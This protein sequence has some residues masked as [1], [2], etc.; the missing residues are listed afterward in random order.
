MRKVTLIIQYSK[1]YESYSSA[2]SVVWRKGISEESRVIKI[3]FYENDGGM[4]ELALQETEE[5]S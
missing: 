3:S 2:M 5:M 1:Y 4:N